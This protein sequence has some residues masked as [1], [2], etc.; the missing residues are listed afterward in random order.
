MMN[1]LEIE[2]DRDELLAEAL[3]EIHD[4]F[5]GAHGRERYVSQLLHP[6]GPADRSQVDGDMGRVGDLLFQRFRNRA[7]R[8]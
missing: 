8:A 7:G 3:I 5:L 1:R 2:I 6:I 4:Q